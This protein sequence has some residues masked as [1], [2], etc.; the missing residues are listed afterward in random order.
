MLVFQAACS[1]LPDAVGGEKGNRAKRMY[2]A[3]KNVGVWSLDICSLDV[4]LHLSS[5]VE[6]NIR[7]HTLSGGELGS[8]RRAKMWS[9]EKL[10]V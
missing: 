2:K 7:A 9:L 4:V 8:W 3:D 6:L 5:Y 10:E 1:H